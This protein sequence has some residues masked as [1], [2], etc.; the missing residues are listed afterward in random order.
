VAVDWNI[1]EGKGKER[2]EGEGEEMT[3]PLHCITSSHH[4]HHH[5]SSYT[6]YKLTHTLSHIPSQSYILPLSPRPGLAITLAARYSV[7]KRGEADS[8]S[9]SG[10]RDTID[11]LFFYISNFSL[12]LFFSYLIIFWFLFF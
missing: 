4:H 1:G 12:L 7:D 2:E 10:S 8:D 5:S 3:Y 6:P 9:D 11:L